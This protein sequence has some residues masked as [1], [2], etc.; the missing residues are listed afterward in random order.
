MFWHALLQIHSIRINLRRRQIP[1]ASS[2]YCLILFRS[3]ISRAVTEAPEMRSPSTNRL[4][5]RTAHPLLHHRT[6]AKG[7]PSPSKLCAQGK[8]NTALHPSKIQHNCNT[9]ALSISAL[10][11]LPQ[12]RRKDPRLPAWRLPKS[13]LVTTAPNKW[14]LHY[15]P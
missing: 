14:F 4:S 5:P 6:Q 8:A 13:I 2:W 15:H 10:E 7:L 11:L 3:R 12:K 1:T 9:A